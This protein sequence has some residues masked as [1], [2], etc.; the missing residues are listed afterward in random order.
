MWIP[1][2]SNSEIFVIKVASS[3]WPRL[4]SLFSIEVYDKS[5]N[6]VLVV[7]GVLLQQSYPLIENRDFTGRQRLLVHLSECGEE[8]NN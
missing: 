7:V 8:M 2:I 6:N 4:S 1:F 5:Q 3:N